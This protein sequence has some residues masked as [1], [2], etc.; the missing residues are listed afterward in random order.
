MIKLA[1]DRFLVAGQG[2]HLDFV[3]LTGPARNPEYLSIEAGTFDGER[4]V[5][6]RVLDGDE[7]SV[8]LPPHQSRILQV[9]L[10]RRKWQ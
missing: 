9:H 1:P 5:P 4:W 10:N 8:T 2:F 7:A 3:E 6:S